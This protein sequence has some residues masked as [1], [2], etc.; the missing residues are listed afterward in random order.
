MGGR[1][2]LERVPVL[3][4][5]RHRLAARVLAAAARH[6][7]VVDLIDDLERRWGSDP[8]SAEDAER[9]RELREQ[10]R[11]ARLEHDEAVR[12]LRRLSASLG[13]RIRR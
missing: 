2:D 1:V 3:L 4:A 8:M 12:A 7:A 13:M 5:A 6:S 10:R 11:E 9:Y